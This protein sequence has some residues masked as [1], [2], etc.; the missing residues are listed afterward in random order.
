MKKFYL[1]LLLFA[2]LHAISQMAQAQSEFSNPTIQIGVVVSDLEK[3]TDFY[4]QVIGMVKTDGFSVDGEFAKNSGLTAGE[5]F[6]VTVLKLQDSPFANEWKLMSFNR[7]AGQNRPAHI[8]DATGMR[9]ITIFLHDLK[10]VVKRIRDNGIALLGETPVLMDDSRYFVLIQ[11]PDGIFV[12]L[13]GAMV[14]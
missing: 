8:E 2:V 10:P 13:I 3:S 9:Y 11:D 14:P 4:T 6:D 12:E 5:A 7:P 1:N